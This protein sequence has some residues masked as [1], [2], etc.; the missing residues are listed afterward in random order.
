[1]LL[2][3]SLGPTSLPLSLV[4]LLPHLPACMPEPFTPC[5]SVHAFFSALCHLY[6]YHACVCH[7]CPFCA[8]LGDSGVMPCCH[9]CMQCLQFYHCVCACIIFILP[10]YA[11]RSTCACTYAWAVILQN[12]WLSQTP[13]IHLLSPAPAC[14]S[15]FPDMPPSSVASTP[16]AIT[17]LLY[18]T[19]NL[20]CHAII[21]KKKKKKEG[22]LYF[23]SI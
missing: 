16:P 2:S 10:S 8:A 3:L 19:P 17:F 6:Y 13:D 5:L 4:E 9:S 21:L 18:A 14:L 11:F 7:T 1:M 22:E 15:L 20:P 23:P 12:G